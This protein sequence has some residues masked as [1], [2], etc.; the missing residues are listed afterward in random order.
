MHMSSSVGVHVFV[1]VED[2]LKMPSER[3]QYGLWRTGTRPSVD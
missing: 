3:R 2:D 1:L